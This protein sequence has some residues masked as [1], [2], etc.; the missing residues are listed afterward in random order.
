MTQYKWDLN[1]GKAPTEAE[2]ASHFDGLESFVMTKDGFKNNVYPSALSD[3]IMPNNKA[4]KNHPNDKSAQG[5]CVLA[6]S[7]VTYTFNVKAGKTYYL[8]NFGSKI[9]FYGFSFDEDE[10]KTVDQVEYDADNVNTNNKVEKT[11]EGH[12]AQVKIAR[13]W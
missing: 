10:T 13:K 5:W 12:V 2:V 3:D 1:G 11:A 6:D 4:I 7:P 9:G 8:Y